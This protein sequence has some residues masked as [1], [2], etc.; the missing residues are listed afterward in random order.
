MDL[1]IHLAGILVAYIVFRNKDI[2]SRAERFL[3]S[4]TNSFEIV[5]HRNVEVRITLLSDDV[6]TKKGQPVVPTNGLTQ[7]QIE[8][9]DN[10][11]NPD[12]HQEP[13]KGRKVGNPVQRIESIIHEQR[14]ETAWLQTAEKGIPGS[15]NRLKP[16]RNQVLPQDGIGQMI[17]L[18]TSQQQL[19][20]KLTRELNRLKINDG[21]ALSKEHN[22]SPSLLHDSNL[23]AKYNKESM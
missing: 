3:S 8:S 16:E 4:I 14:L 18:E 5:L 13:L 7:R 6:T 1:Y 23:A 20:D 17:S 9:T 10:L 19:E 11:S 2:K 21:K 15:L 12:L 22:I